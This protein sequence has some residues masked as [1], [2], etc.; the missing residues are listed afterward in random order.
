MLFEKI[1]GC[2]E[3]LF[4]DKIVVVR[5][6]PDCVRVEFSMQASADSTF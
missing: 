4:G 2:A 6:E 5:E 3:I 1:K